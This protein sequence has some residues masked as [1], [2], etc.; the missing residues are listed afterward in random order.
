VVEHRLPVLQ[1]GNQDIPDR[2]EVADLVEQRAEPGDFGDLAIDVD[3]GQH[4][5]LPWLAATSTCRAAVS[6]RR[7]AQR[8][9]STAIARGYAGTGMPAASQVPIAAASR[10]GSRAGTSRRII[11][12]DG[13]RAASMPAARRCRRADQRSHSAI[14][15]YDR[16]PATTALLNRSCPPSHPRRGRVYT[17]QSKVDV[18]T[19]LPGP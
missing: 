3:A 16:W 9:P 1:V 2:M 12:S 7:A 18:V 6:A 8:L 14:A 11:A 19:T 17:N 4:G 10:A 13:R 5:T 15:V